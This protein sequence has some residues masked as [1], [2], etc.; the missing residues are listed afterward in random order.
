MS[1]TDKKT[2]NHTSSLLCCPQCKG[3]LD[4]GKTEYKCKNCHLRFQILNGIP[5]LFVPNEWPDSK[6]DVTETIRDFYEKTPFPNYDD[7]DDVGSLIDKSRRGVFSRLLDEQ[8]PLGSSI[9]ECGC[10]TGQLSNFLAVANRQVHGV[11]MCINSLKLASDFKNR[12]GLSRVEFTQMN[13]FRPCFLEEE[14]DLVISNGVL[15]HTSDP[16]LAFK[17]IS[18]LVKPGGYILIGLYHRY[19]RFATDVRR[20]IFHLTGDRMKWLDR[21][22]ASGLD[23]KRKETWFKDQYKNPHE[24]KHTI[25]Q[26]LKWFDETDFSFIRTIPSTMPFKSLDSTTYLF[27]PEPLS[28]PLARAITTSTMLLSGH[29]EGGFFIMIGQRK[30]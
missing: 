12:N 5:Q 22:W 6:N 19:G 14:F 3:E 27:E 25:N 1:S 29:K 11:D 24:S 2:I 9:L 15:H 13:L 17:T 7:F 23:S 4:H 20:K 21:R 26:V 18:K 8:I 16:R 30:K 28:S 10:G